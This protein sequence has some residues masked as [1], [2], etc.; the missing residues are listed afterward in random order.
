MINI[1]IADD[2]HLV[3]Q[4]LRALLELEE[5]IEVVGE[6]RDGQETIELVAKLKPDVLLL[7]I[8][9]PQMDGIDVA[10]R[11]TERGYPTRIVVLSMY[12]NRSLVRNAFRNG[13]Y[14]YLLKYA[15]KEELFFA[16]KEAHNGRK[17]VSPSIA[18]KKAAVVDRLPSQA[19][20]SGIYHTLSS[21]ELQ[22]L[23][24]IAKGFTNNATALEL[25]ISIKTVEKHHSEPH[26]QIESP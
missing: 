18:D 2:Q 13:V 17:Y 6:A 8:K 12:T 1:L 11:I 5:N 9:M 24:F 21:R 26:A 25:G 19:L 15:V 20:D 7:D 16:I 22:I 3:R 4:G 10:K 14:A 23:K